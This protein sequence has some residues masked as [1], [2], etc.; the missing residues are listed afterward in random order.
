MKN[1]I[2]LFPLLMLVAMPMITSCSKDRP[3]VL[4]EIKQVT[5]Y[6][7]EKQAVAYIDYED[8]N[9]IFL[10]DGIP[11]AYLVAVEDEE[12]AD[13]NE[14]IGFNGK[15]L[16]WYCDGIMYDKSGYAV[17]AEIGI[18]RGQILTT[19][20]KIESVKGIKHIKPIKHIREVSP[21]RHILADSWSD[22]LLTDFLNEGIKY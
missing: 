22:T 2:T 5:L 18:E 9:T 20:V 19:L 3:E 13:A 6:D 8:E 11:V 1:P 21:V 15:C 14:V 10:W 17:G 4:S 12:I 16:G 7:H